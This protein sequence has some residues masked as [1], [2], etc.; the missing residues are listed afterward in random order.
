MTGYW[1]FFKLMIILNVGHSSAERCDRAST[2]KE[3]EGN[4]GQSGDFQWLGVLHVQLRE[5]I[6]TSGI[7]LIKFKHALVN[8]G[9]VARI[10]QHIFKSKSRIMFLPT[11][12]S[13]LFVKP[14]S[15]VTHPEYEISSV[16]SIAIIELDLNDVNDFPLSPVCLAT[17][18]ILKASKYLYLTGFT[19]E[20]D[21]L[22][23]VIYKIQHLDKKVCDEYYNKTELSSEQP[24][25]SAN[26]CGYAPYT[27]K[28]CVWENGMTLLYNDF[29]YLY[30]IGFGVHGPGC[31]APARFIDLFPYFHWINFITASEGYRRKEESVPNNRLIEVVPKS[32]RKLVENIPIHE[33]FTQG[34]RRFEVLGH[35]FEKYPYQLQ[36]SK[37]LI[38]KPTS[39]NGSYLI[40][41]D[42]EWS[43]DDHS[44]ELATKQIYREVFEVKAVDN[45]KGYATYKLSLYDLL[46][47]ECIC[48]RLTVDCQKRSD[49][50]LAFREEINFLEDTELSVDRTPQEIIRYFPNKITE[51]PN[52]LGVNEALFRPTFIEHDDLSRTVDNYELYITFEFIE[53]GKLEFEMLA[54]RVATTA[55][56][57]TEETEEIETE[58]MET[59]KIETKAPTESQTE[60]IKARRAKVKGKVKVKGKG[61]GKVKV[62]VKVKSRWGLDNWA[63]NVLTEDKLNLVADVEVYELQNAARVEKVP[64]VTVMVGLL[65][66]VL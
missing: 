49:A 61:K 21:V 26:L 1:L 56:P 10:P 62:K 33:L 29:G 36:Q 39:K 63:D 9:D 2:V 47:S 40:S 31:A 23:K 43:K 15:Y 55:S 38:S 45:L 11:R 37:F 27:R 3:R 5:L 17:A 35:H 53:R 59:E 51:K 65:L 4:L 28:Q 52:K 58:K 22:E 12:I 14:A 30:L 66:A 18:K 44:C 54:A 7:V 16:N 48:V 20:N 6:A 60:K 32:K 13:P 46:H 25:P 57:M 19:H 8:A 64:W 50:V 34:S 42:N 41:F 24:I